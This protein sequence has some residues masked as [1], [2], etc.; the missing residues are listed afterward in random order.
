MEKKERQ[1]KKRHV[2][3]NLLLAV[4]VVTFGVSGSLLLRDLI[5]NRKQDAAFE[6]I[7]EKLQSPAETGEMPRESDSGEEE[8]RFAAYRAL[9]DENSDMAGWIRIEG[10]PVDYPVMFTP[11]RPEYYLHRDFHKEKSSY[12]TPF[13]AENC[14]LESP[15]SSLLVYGHHM[16]NGSMFAALQNYTGKEYWSQHPQVQFDTLDETGSYEI[17]AVV[18]LQASGNAVPWQDLLFPEDEAEFDEAWKVFRKHMFYETGVELTAEDE[19]LAL[20][21]CEYTLKDGRLMVI[22]KRI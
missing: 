14:R 4:C 9:H 5:S 20:V 19:L 18:K 6:E 12:G 11:D 13:L 17:A 3:Y 2:L 8:A 10:T 21:T 16:K 7:R 22:A 1:K 15:R